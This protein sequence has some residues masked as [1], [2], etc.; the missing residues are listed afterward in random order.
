MVLYFLVILFPLLVEGLYRKKVVQGGLLGD[1]SRNR[2]IRRRYIFF[3]AL[4][5]FLLIAFRNES[6]GNDTAWYLHHFEKIADTPWS[7]IFK[8][9]TVEEGYILFAKIISIFTDNSSIYQVI[10]ATIYLL[11]LTSFTNQQEENHF[12]IL[13]LFA[14]MGMYTFMFTG[15]RQCLAISLCLFSYK[16]IKKRKII[17]FAILMAIAFHFHRSSI[18]FAVAYF[19]YSRKLSFVNTLIYCAIIVFVVLYLDIIQEWFNDQLDYNYGIEGGAGGIIFSLI[20]IAMCIF[21]IYLIVSNKAMT[22]NTQ[23]LINI[24]IIATILWVL[25]IFTRV[26]ERPSYYFLICVFASFAYAISTI[27]DQKEKEIIRVLVIF[28]AL[29]LFGYRLMVNQSTLMPYK[30]FFNFNF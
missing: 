19:I 8:N 22:K 5:M 25:R 14:T 18:L 3:S 29:A 6:M 28:F 9:A 16:Y 10:C 1:D 21:A 4:P 20:T 23:G 11:G 24:G 27:K 13:F 26:A 7:Q 12:F 17:P 2:K 15:T 30:F